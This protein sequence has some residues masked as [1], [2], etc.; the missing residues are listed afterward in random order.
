MAQFIMGKWKWCP[1]GP[2]AEVRK[3]PYDYPAVNP[4]HSLRFAEICAFFLLNFDL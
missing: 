3:E 1:V 4:P 2:A